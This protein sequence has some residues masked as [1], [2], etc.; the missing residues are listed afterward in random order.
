VSLIW[1]SLSRF[2]LAWHRSWIVRLARRCSSSS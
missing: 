1:P 2:M